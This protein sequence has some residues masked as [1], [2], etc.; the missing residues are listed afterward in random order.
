MTLKEFQSLCSSLPGTSAGFP[1]DESVLVCKVAD[2]MFALTNF[3]TFE[4]ISLKCD[5]DD[6]AALCAAFPAVSPGYHLNKRHWHT[7]ICQ[8]N[9]PDSEIMKMIDHSYEFMVKSLPKREREKLA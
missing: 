9:L 3:H 7:V 5:P 1:F 2:K 6:A 4:S 8:G